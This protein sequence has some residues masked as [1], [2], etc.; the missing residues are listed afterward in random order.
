M[1][2]NVPSHVCKRDGRIVPFRADH[3]LHSIT[4]AIVRTG[5]SS[6]M[7]RDIADIVTADISAHFAG[8]TPTTGEI[9]R[10]I[11]DALTGANL[12]D[13]A[14]EYSEFAARRK[15]RRERITVVVDENDVFHF[16]PVQESDGSR[17]RWS[18][19]RFEAGLCLKA[20]VPM[21]R[22]FEVGAFV[23]AVLLRSGMKTVTT[24][25]LLAL[26]AQKLGMAGGYIGL[27]R[28]KRRGRTGVHDPQV[29]LY[30]EGLPYSC[31]RFDLP[32]L[33]SGACSGFPEIPLA[34]PF[35]YNREVLA[36][37]AMARIATDDW[38]GKVVLTG[39]ERL[40]RFGN[41]HQG[42]LAR[43]ISSVIRRDSTAEIELAASLNN[44][45]SSEIAQL[46]RDLS[47]VTVAMRAVTACLQLSFENAPQTKDALRE[48]CVSLPK[49]AQTIF[50][51]REPL[52]GQPSGRAAISAP[53]IFCGEPSETQTLLE[54]CVTVCARSIAERVEQKPDVEREKALAALDA[55][56]DEPQGGQ[57]PWGGIELAGFAECVEL[58]SGGAV[59]DG[60][61]GT[62][63]A[64]DLLDRAAATVESAGREAGIKLRLSINCGAIP[65]RSFLAL[66]RHRR[67]QVG[68]VTR[69]ESYQ[70]GPSITATPGDS[71][72]PAD[73]L[74]AAALL[75]RLV[76]SPVIIDLSAVGGEIAQ[77]LGDTVCCGEL[78]SVLLING[79]VL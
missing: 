41:T 15:S 61:A 38:C 55:P 52:V 14:S 65:R 45:K 54:S 17:A 9:S 26:A 70:P 7:A 19:G 76:V 16:E 43:T 57:L 25:V 58:L 63:C 35:D 67:P 22:A 27:L 13:A 71:L 29:F 5:R 74:Q 8:R 30:D 33:V 23:E 4:T 59:F 20:D 42:E 75:Q 51:L 3:L 32:H 1:S 50:A 36:A 2:G 53:F 60:E 64:F 69:G 47:D 34:P 39:M 11:A 24:S 66:D 73:S 18:R 37:A 40:S 44:L 68:I 10:A 6:D 62:A 48:A 46:V 12:V 21:R 31:L 78:A 77:V 56:A 79:E 49:G 72:F 28:S